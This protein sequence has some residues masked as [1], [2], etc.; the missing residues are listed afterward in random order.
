MSY[1]VCF[2]LYSDRCSTDKILLQLHTTHFTAHYN[3]L[4]LWVCYAV[5]HPLLGSGL[6]QRRIPFTASELSNACSSLAGDWLVTA[7]LNCRFSTLYTLSTRLV[8]S[9]YKFGTDHIENTASNG[10][11]YFLPICCRGNIFIESLSH[12]GQYRYVT[13]SSSFYIPGS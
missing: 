12:S 7:S 9:L 4:S 13:I 10:A 6:R 1:I 5:M 3:M 11:S 8:S 2:V